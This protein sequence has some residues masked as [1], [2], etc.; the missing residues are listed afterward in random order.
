MIVNRTITVEIDLYSLP[1]NEWPEEAKRIAY[2]MPQGMLHRIKDLHPLERKAEVVRYVENR[3]P[4][5]LADLFGE[6]E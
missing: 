1:F 3:R 4:L 6:L 5:T 2:N